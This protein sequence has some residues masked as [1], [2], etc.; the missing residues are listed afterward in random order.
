MNFNMD[1]K[2]KELYNEKI[3]FATGWRVAFPAA[4]KP[5]PRTREGG[6]LLPYRWVNEVTGER[7]YD[8]PDFFSDLDAI[9]EAEKV[10]T[11]KQSQEYTTYLIQA[12]QTYLNGPPPEVFRV[13]HATASQRAE[14]FLRTLGLWEE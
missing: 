7:L 12:Q 6:I 13:I 8:L 2:R 5:H 4:G 3:G 1:S 11:V 10:L 14:A 9:H